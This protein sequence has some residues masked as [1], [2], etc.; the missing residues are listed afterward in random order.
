MARIQISSVE[1]PFDQPDVGRAAIEVLGLSDA[2]GLLPKSAEF[3]QLGWV[4]VHAVARHI[5]KAGIA[6]AVVPRLDKKLDPISLREVLAQLTRILRE[7]PAP[8]YEWDRLRQVFP[9]EELAKLLGVS[10][11]SVE[12]YRSQ[13][14]KTPD[15]VAARLH[16][17]ARVL[18]HL[19]GAYSELG[20]RRW[21]LR[22]R[23]ALDEKAPAQILR[24]AWDP[25]SKEALRVLDLAGTLNGTSAT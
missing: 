22:P 24:R 6:T 13:R 11:A 17:L 14:R 23:T 15:E 10:S 16:F 1:K 7:N 25:N 4:T 5:A 8:E 3:K 2:M 12:R 9:A 18:H 20:V 21:F 19:E